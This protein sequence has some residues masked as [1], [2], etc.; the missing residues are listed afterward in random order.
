MTA[1]EICL[2]DVAG[3]AIAERNGADRVELCANLA[4][5][6]TTPSIGTIATVLASVTT[7]DVQ[8][9]VRQ[10]PGDF[11]YAP[12]EVAAMVHDIETIGALVRPAGVKVG[13]VIG[14]LTRDQQVDVPVL[15]RL[16]RACDSSPVT[17]HKAFDSVPDQSTA[18]E[19]IIDLGIE[20]VLTSGGQATAVAGLSNLASLVE[21]ANGRTSVLAGG[22]IRA[23][24]VEGIV[25]GSGVREVHLRATPTA[26]GTTTSAEVV[27]AVVASLA[28]VAPERPT[29][30]IS[31]GDQVGTVQ[32]E[33]ANS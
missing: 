16:V 4:Q 25:R 33:E 10:R 17:F 24:N 29:S 11:C 23:H 19:I 1:L 12:L 31:P 3:A 20:R 7:V 28:R 21:Q 8:V 2:D 15:A 30:P 5:G 27:R 26:G 18:L 14:A 13:F 6:G 9:L 22:G 32:N